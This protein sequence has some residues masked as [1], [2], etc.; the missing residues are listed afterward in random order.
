MDQEYYIKKWLNGTITEAEKAEFEKLNDFQVINKISESLSAF[1]AP[2]YDAH[3]ELEKFHLKSTS[4]GKEVKIRFLVPLLRIAAVLVLVAT[5]FFYFYLNANTSFSTLAREKSKIT[6]PDDSNIELNVLTSVSYKKRIWDISRK[7]ELDGEAYFKVAKGSKFEV[8]TTEGIVSV[9]GTQFNVKNRENFFEVVCFEGLVEVKS[10]KEVEE[11]A[12]GHSFRI[13][14]GVVHKRDNVHEIA[15][16]WVNNISSFQSVPF[17]Q[18]IQEFE[19]QYGV[20]VNTQDIDLNQ[21]F[22]GKFIHNDQKL[23]LQSISIPLNLEYTLAEENQIILS[24]KGD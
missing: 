9:L 24:G 15:P 3:A 12:P 8:E 6:L 14:N 2:N 11:L 7:V 19:I 18:V 21:L 13:I 17:S 1:K 10:D 23:A 22:T 5:S 20:K 16:S 4:Q